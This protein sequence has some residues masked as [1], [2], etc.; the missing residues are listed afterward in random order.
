[1]SAKDTNV[2]KETE[3]MVAG[4][5]RLNGYPGAE[6]TVRT[7][8]R[9]TGRESADQ[10]DIDGTP[11]ICWQVKSLR[12]NARA[13]L[14]VPAWLAETEQQRVASGADLGF[15]V[16]RRWGTT[17]VGRWWVFQRLDQLHTL[18]CEEG[19]DVAEH[20]GVGAIPVRMDMA[21]LSGLLTRTGWAGI[22]AAS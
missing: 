7:G 20:Y 13:E 6:R 3:R 9:V 10:G 19:G 22:E 14:A 21:A 8:Y 17:D 15:L 5:L 18:A 1:V 4:W 12:P 11:G 2:G 16:V